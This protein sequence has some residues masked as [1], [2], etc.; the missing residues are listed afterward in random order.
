MTCTV[1]TLDQGIQ[2]CVGV[3]NDEQWYAGEHLGVWW[4]V[5]VR[6]FAPRSGRSDLHY[7]EFASGV[8][9]VLVHMGNQTV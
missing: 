6:G 8:T 1:S 5:V 2:W 7:M 3:Y 4:Y 9:D